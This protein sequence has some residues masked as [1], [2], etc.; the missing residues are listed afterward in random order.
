MCDNFFR[1]FSAGG[2]TKLQTH[3]GDQAIDDLFIMKSLLF[4][5][6]KKHVK[7]GDAENVSMSIEPT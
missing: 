2:V 5:L 6:K 7:C 1:A 3:L 4:A